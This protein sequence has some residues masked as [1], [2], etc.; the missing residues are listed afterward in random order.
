MSLSPRRPPICFPSLWICLSS[1]FLQMESYDMWPF[2]SG[3]WHPVSR[4]QRPSMLQPVPGP[5]AF[6]LSHVLW[7]GRIAFYLPADGRLGRVWFLA[8]V[9][10]AAPTDRS[11]TGFSVARVPISP[12]RSLGSRTAEAD[13]PPEVKGRGPARLFP[14]QPLGHGGG[15]GPT[16]SL[17]WVR[18]LV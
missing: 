18:T 2:V 14:T 3:A 6:W 1:H 11:R 9:H 5:C 8:T 4:S 13:G 15:P 10:G 16:S 17:P 7:S 12:G